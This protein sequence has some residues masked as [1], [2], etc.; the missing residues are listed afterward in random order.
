MRR[1]SQA[2]ARALTATGPFEHRVQRGLGIARPTFGED[3]A[4]PVLHA[5][6]LTRA[7]RPGQRSMG[8]GQVGQG[9]RGR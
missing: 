6:V 2:A 7:Q 3:L 5:E 9:P 1:R 8:L 4:Q